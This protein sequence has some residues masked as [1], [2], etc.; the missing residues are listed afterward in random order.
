MD[1]WKPDFDEVYHEEEKPKKKKQSGPQMPDLSKLFGNNSKSIED[2]MKNMMKGMGID[3]D[4]LGDDDDDITDEE[5]DQLLDKL[6]NMIGQLSGTKP[7]VKKV[8]LQE[9]YALS[10]YNL[11]KPEDFGSLVFNKDQ[12]LYTHFMEKYPNPV[13]ALQDSNMKFH[14]T[15]ITSQLQLEE[16]V[17]LRYCKGNENLLYFYAIPDETDEDDESEYYG[18]Y[19]AFYKNEDNEWACVIPEYGNT[20]YYDPKTGT[21]DLYDITEYPMLFQDTTK[22][23]KMVVFN[24]SALEFGTEWLLSCNQKPMMTPALFGTIKNVMDPVNEDGRY[25]RIGTITSNESADAILLKKDAEVN[26]NQT[27]FPFY[28]KLKNEFTKETLRPIAS[29]LFNVDW[30]SNPLM[31]LSELKYTS[32]FDKKFYIDVDLGDTI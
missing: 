16:I 4:S 30:N 8:S 25:I 21:A 13:D 2:A 17:D 15:N 14:L 5:A 32:G 20:F 12:D 24:S 3:L 9:L 18:F 19:L 1:D 27:E 29:I 23:T 10:D 11:L 26:I 7:S 31:F 28:I 22:G 6:T